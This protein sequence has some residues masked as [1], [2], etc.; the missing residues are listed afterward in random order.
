M[1]KKGHIVAVETKG[2]HLSNED[3]FTKARLGY[4]LDMHDNHSQFSCFYYAFD[5]IFQN[6]FIQ[7]VH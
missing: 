6:L 3:Q 7:R 2:G 4:L 5:Q 1:T